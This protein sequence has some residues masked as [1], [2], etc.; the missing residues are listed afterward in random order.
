MTFSPRKLLDT[1]VK[2][3]ENKKAYDAIILDI[4]RLSII[5][6][7]FVIFSGR[8]V[9]HV[10][11]IA[12]EI[13][14]E[15]ARSHGLVPRQEGLRGGQWVLLDYGDVVVHVFREQERQFYNLERLWGN[16]RV[17]TVDKR[18]SLSYN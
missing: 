16:A 4:S 10:Q 5:A 12:E 6:D 17:Q 1:I 8:S 3:A 7:Y 2:A 14:E 15:V 11:A 13:I 18:A 9:T